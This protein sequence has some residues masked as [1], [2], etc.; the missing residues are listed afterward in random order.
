MFFISIMCG[1]E[2]EQERKIQ[3]VWRKIIS[4]L[5][6]NWC[7]E[8]IWRECSTLKTTKQLP[9]VENKY[10]ITK[11]LSGHIFLIFFFFVLLTLWHLFLERT[12]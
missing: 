10:I 9:N 8:T 4:R 12:F 3:T 6:C 5:R 1:Y 11:R 2:Q 7:M